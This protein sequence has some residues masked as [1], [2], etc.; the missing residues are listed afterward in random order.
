MFDGSWT[1]TKPRFRS[2]L[3]IMDLGDPGFCVLSERDTV[4]LE[5]HPLNV[6]VP[7]IDGTRS[8]A[9]A[10][11]D[12]TPKLNAQD[13]HNAVIFLRDSGFLE[14]ADNVGP[15]AINSLCN[16]LGITY[17]D[18]LRLIVSRPIRLINY[19]SIHDNHFLRNLKASGIT[20]DEHQPFL[21]VVLVD[22]YHD[23]RLSALNFAFLQNQ[24]PWLIAKVSGYNTW[25]G[26]LFLFQRSACWSCLDYRLTRNRELISHAE[27]IQGERQPVKLN[28][29]TVA[30]TQWQAYGALITQ[31]VRI[32]VDRLDILLHEQLKVF[33][34]IQLTVTAHDVVRRPECRSCGHIEHHSLRAEMYRPRDSSLATTGYGGQRRESPE[35]TYERFKHH[36]SPITGIVGSV[37]AS[38]YNLYTPLRIYTAGHNF[39]L[40][41]ITPAAAKDS[42]RALSS[43][44]GRTDAEARTSALCEALE[45]Y[46]GMFQGD[47]KRTSASLT[48]L[49]SEALNPRDCM[50][51]SADQYRDRAAWLQRGSQ[52]QVVPHP[53]DPKREI[54]WS[55]VVD[56]TSREQRYLPT[57]YLYYGYT[58]NNPFMCWADSNGCAGGTSFDD[59]CLQG[60]LELVERDAAAI[61][62][63]NRL[64][65]PKACETLLDDPYY[66]SLQKYY[67]SQ[68]REFWVLDLTHDLGIPVFCAVN[69]R[70]QGPTEDII[71]GFGAHLDPG[72]AVSRAVT[73]MNQFIPAVLEVDPQG[74]THYTFADRDAVNWWRSATI[75]NQPYLIPSDQAATTAASRQATQKLSIEEMLEDTASRI[76]RAGSPIYFLDQTRAEVGLP[77]VKMIAPGLRH[78][79]ARFAPGRLFD[80]PVSMG[81]FEKSLSEADLNP[82]PLFI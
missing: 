77:V 10:I 23:E 17:R 37:V 31:I 34:T 74:N 55:P 69:R 33:D 50:L 42:I 62:W 39:A 4:L 52:F 47:E 3:Q 20:I 36:I 46:S 61:W 15:I 7:L 9:Q 80:V 22:D 56:L 11:S 30:S 66:D 63:Y 44:K 1:N 73:E 71:M 21:S 38:P 12:A 82:I 18:A 41:R 29:S 64:S 60:L 13:A 59:A 68:K 72:I 58:A 25:I 6:M 51:F 19:S 26:P 48:S 5:G 65:M 49:G 32:L 81:R 43:G 76:I 79:W 27:R 45:R 53:F 35:V 75:S 78:F 70:I 40:S 14:D 67:Q 54:E 28:T 8:V 24:H 57:S 16:E 2:N